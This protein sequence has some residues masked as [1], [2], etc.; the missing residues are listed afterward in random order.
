GPAAAIQS[1]LTAIP[2]FSNA[3][4]S[5]FASER[6]TIANMKK[7]ILM[8]A[9]TAVQTYMMKLAKEQEILMRIA[10]MII[11]T[12][13]SESMLLRAMK[14]ATEGAAQADLHVAMARVYLQDSMDRMQVN[15]RQS[16]LAMSKGDQQRMLL[17]G[18]KRFTK[19]EGY[20]AVLARRAVS[21]ALT[22]SNRY[23]F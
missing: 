20:N 16:V 13:M 8:V 4:D 3:D 12:F 6:K 10:D 14:S 19:S 1:E 15:G 5:A 21:D 2:D 23:C 7:A 9:G 18:L 22:S 11:D 17:M